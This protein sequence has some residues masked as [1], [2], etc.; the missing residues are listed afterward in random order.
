PA[1]HAGK[2]FIQSVQL[3]IGDMQQMTQP[4]NCSLPSTYNLKVAHPKYGW[5][6][7]TE[8]IFQSII[9]PW[10]VPLDEKSG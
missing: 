6:H 5:N 9:H 4:S 7:S 8:E 10:W 3:W 2:L 1:F